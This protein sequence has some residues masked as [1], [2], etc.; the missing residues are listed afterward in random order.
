MKPSE[1]KNRT[2]P[3]TQTGNQG[4]PQEPEFKLPD[5]IEPDSEEAYELVREYD[6]RRFA[7]PA[8]R[9]EVPAPE[10]H[11]AFADLDEE[12]ESNAQLTAH[13]RL[14]TPEEILRSR[15]PSVTSTADRLG[16]LLNRPPR[17]PRPKHEDA[18][19]EVRYCDHRCGPKRQLPKDHRD[20]HG[21]LTLP[22]EL[23]SHETARTQN[24]C[25]RCGTKHNHGSRPHLPA[26]NKHGQEDDE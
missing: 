18:R 11:G 2:A 14:K 25:P 13:R 10:S 7:R 23:L 21:K 22:G 5:G 17:E 1:S 16:E 15:Q 20:N 24:A 8:T 3:S 6:R 19:D 12:Y 4:E 26:A 9:Q